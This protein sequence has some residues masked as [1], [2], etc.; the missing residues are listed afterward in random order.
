M[1][2]TIRVPRTGIEPAREY[3]SQRILSPSCLPIPPP[4]QTL[5]LKGEKTNPLSPLHKSCQIPTG[6]LPQYLKASF[7]PR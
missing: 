3:K 1:N 2:K 6:K 7:Y 5:S 4:R